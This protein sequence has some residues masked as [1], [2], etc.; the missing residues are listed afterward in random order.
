MGGFSLIRAETQLLVLS[1]FPVD[2]GKVYF[3]IVTGLAEAKPPDSSQVDAE[4]WGSIPMGWGC[5]SPGS[6]QWDGVQGEQLILHPGSRWAGC[7]VGFISHPGFFG[8]SGEKK[9]R[10]CWAVAEESAQTAA[11]PR[12]I[13]T[14]IGGQ[15][16]SALPE[17]APRVRLEL[18]Q[19]AAQ[20]SG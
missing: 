17:Q 20:G 4:V 13:N 18:S 7:S 16:C 15:G 9:Q 19:K 10:A 2:A 5:A 6:A 12:V 1:F 3:G 14:E 8:W 11:E